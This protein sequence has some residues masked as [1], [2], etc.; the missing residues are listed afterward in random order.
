MKTSCLIECILL[1]LHVGRDNF[2]KTTIYSV[3]SIEPNQTHG[4]EHHNPPQPHSKSI[5]L[6]NELRWYYAATVYLSTQK[7]PVFFENKFRLVCSQQRL[8]KF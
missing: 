3:E 6:M 8:S 5:S 7:N 2:K 4:V 1:M